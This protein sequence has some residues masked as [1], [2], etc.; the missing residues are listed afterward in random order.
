MQTPD[1]SPDHGP[2]LSVVIPTRNEAANAPALVSQLAAVLGPISSEVIFV[3]D[4]DDGTPAALEAAAVDAGLQLSV[5][6]REGAERKGGLSTAVLAGIREAGGAYVLIMDADLQH[7]TDLI[8]PL[9]RR[10]EET[11]ADIVIASRFVP[12]GSDKGLAGTQRRVISWGAKTL[13]K[14][15]FLRTLRGV[16]DPLSGFFLARR[17]LL[18]DATLRPIGFKILLDILIRCGHSRVEELPLVFAAR[19]GGDSKAT[20]SQGKDFLT[21]VLTLFRDVRFDGQLRRVRNLRSHGRSRSG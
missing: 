5:V 20:L 19:A 8:T 14:T 21:H 15:L 6:H 18:M 7:P 12:G 16:T 1:L 2:V 3:D 11:D 17:E 4:S 9:L 13:V 10:A